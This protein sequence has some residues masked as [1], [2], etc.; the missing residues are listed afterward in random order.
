M[1]V[2]FRQAQAD[3][4]PL[5]TKGDLCMS[6]AG[7]EQPFDS[8]ESAQDFM[9]ILA[10]M[11]L[12]AVKELNEQHRDAVSQEQD[13]RA[14]AISLALLKLKN[15]NCHIFKCRR[16]L[17]DL[18]LIRRLIVDERANADRVAAAL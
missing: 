2:R 17:N 5:G 12:D 3:V 16:A 11:A 7:M 18:R 9:E 4:K 6:A 10:E 13:R 1:N 14:Q 8:I 15:L